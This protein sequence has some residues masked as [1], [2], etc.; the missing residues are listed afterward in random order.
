MSPWLLAVLVFVTALQ[1]G[2]YW[3]DSRMHKRRVKVMDERLADWKA[4]AD[5]LYTTANT[6]LTDVETQRKAAEMRELDQRL[7]ERSR[8]LRGVS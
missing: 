2:G 5:R 4:L 1:W 3:F 7:E 8:N 6:V